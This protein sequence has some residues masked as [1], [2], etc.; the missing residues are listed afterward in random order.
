[1]D[2]NKDYYSILGVLPTAEDTVIRAAYKALAQ[3]Y[4]P[5]RNSSEDAKVR[6]T[7]INAAY[8]VLSDSAKRTEYDK[9]RSNSSTSDYETYEA[10]DDDISW[11]DELASDWAT[12]V[13][14]FPEAEGHRKQLAKISYRLAF[15]YQIAMLDS[16]EFK[17]AEKIAENMRDGFIE[18]YFGKGSSAKA[19]VLKL[20]ECGKREALLDLNRAVR[21]LGDGVSPTDLQKRIIEKH[22]QEEKHPD[23]RRHDEALKRWKEKNL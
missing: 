4:H 23:Q 19:F 6:M 12:V 9:T 10:D 21:V 18:A 22:C 14:F 5:D 2:T 17:K 16:K 20:I 15:A 7:E 3:R 11:L 8:G 13:E 1:M